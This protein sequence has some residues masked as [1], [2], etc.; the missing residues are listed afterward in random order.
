[1]AIDSE[2]KRRN[3]GMV[4]YVPD[5]AIDTEAERKA[6]LFIYK[7]AV[8][9]IVAAVYRYTAKSRVFRLIGVDRVFRYI[10]NNRSFRQFHRTE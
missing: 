5:G 8:D 4:Y 9:V 7:T 2:N 6:V 3:I 1:M 10:A